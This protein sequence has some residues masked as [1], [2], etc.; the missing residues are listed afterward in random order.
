MTPNEKTWLAVRIK[1]AGLAI[2]AVGFAVGIL[3]KS[4][5]T[6]ETWV[7]FWVCVSV[8][9]VGMAISTVGTCVLAVARYDRTKP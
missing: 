4:L 1:L 7:P 2:I 8:T 3:L 5:E 9:A 6:T